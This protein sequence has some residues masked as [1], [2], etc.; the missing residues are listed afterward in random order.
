[1]IAKFET[2]VEVANAED[3]R[4]RIFGPSGESLSL[5]PGETKD[6]TGDFKAPRSIYGDVMVRIK[7]VHGDAILLQSNLL[8][9]TRPTGSSP[10]LSVIWFR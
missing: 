3:D 4:Q 2:E 1:M 7:D 8:V 5:Q 9:T 6:V 10:E